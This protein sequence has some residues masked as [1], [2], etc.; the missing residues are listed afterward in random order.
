MSTATSRANV[1][2]FALRE[3]LQVSY[4]YIIRVCNTETKNVHNTSDQPF[5]PAFSLARFMQSDDFL[6]TV[7][8]MQFVFD[9]FL[10]KFDAT[11]RICIEIVG[12]LKRRF[13][14]FHA[15]SICSDP[16]L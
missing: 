1:L 3:N 10:L 2:F 13:R 7:M 16:T 12:D 6:H 9:A 5:V 8:S 4:S 15:K 14:L 11:S